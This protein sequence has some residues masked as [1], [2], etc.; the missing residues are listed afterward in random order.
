MALGMFCTYFFFTRFGGANPYL[1]LVA[2]VVLA[3]LFGFIIYAVA[4]AKG[5][6]VRYLSTLLATFAVNMIII[7]IGTALFTTSPR[8]LTSQPFHHPGS[9][10]FAGYSPAG[11]LGCLV[12]NRGPF[13]SFSILPGREGHPSRVQ[14]PGGG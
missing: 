5:D 1:G 3:L 7:G 8:T 13:I 9:R 2:V 12:D 14:Q 11:G 10:H 6:P 4:I